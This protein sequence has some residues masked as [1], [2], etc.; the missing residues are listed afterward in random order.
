MDLA[1]F[2]KR[3]PQKD[4]ET[5]LDEDQAVEEDLKGGEGESV[6]GQISGFLML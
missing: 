1:K 3:T 5:P 4:D 6:V 2:Y